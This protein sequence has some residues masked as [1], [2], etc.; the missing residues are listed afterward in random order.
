M[1]IRVEGMN[2]VMPVKRET[3][4]RVQEYGKLKASGV[5]TGDSLRN[6]VGGT[7]EDRLEFDMAVLY[8]ATS[9]LSEHPKEETPEEPKED[10]KKCQKKS[11]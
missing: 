3:I 9:W 8:L 4:E 6:T 7:P 1:E 2:I 5:M 10:K 11:S